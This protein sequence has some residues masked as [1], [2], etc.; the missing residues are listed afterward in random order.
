MSLVDALNLH[1]ESSEKHNVSIISIIDAY[2]RTREN[3]YPFTA[4]IKRNKTVGFHPSE[5]HGA[6]P[7]YLAFRFLHEKIIITIMRMLT[8]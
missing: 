4:E 5:L 8:S 1:K 6:C 7:R 3:F 2:L